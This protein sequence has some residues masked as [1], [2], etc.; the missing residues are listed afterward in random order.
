M[1]SFRLILW[2]V[3]WLFRLL[4]Q[5]MY[6]IDAKA[7]STITTYRENIWKNEI[8]HPIDHRYDRIHIII[9]GGKVENSISSTIFYISSGIIHILL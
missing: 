2:T 5:R 7:Y 8:D 4:L 9:L 6:R 3:G 1:G